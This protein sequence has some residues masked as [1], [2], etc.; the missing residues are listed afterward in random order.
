MSADVTVLAPV[1]LVRASNTR[2]T[3]KGGKKKAGSKAGWEY[4]EISAGKAA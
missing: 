4:V 1:A 3:P 2:K